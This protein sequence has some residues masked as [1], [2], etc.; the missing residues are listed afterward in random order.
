MMSPRNL[1]RAQYP[2]L[3][4]CQVTACHPSHSRAY[5]VLAVIVVVATT[6]NTEDSTGLQNQGF[7]A[8]DHQ[9][10]AVARERLSGTRESNTDHREPT[11]MISVKAL[12]AHLPILVMRVMRLVTSHHVSLSV[13]SRCP[14]LSQ[15]ETSLATHP[16]ANL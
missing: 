16:S 6:I 14:A 7:P 5:Q 12:G 8:K 10:I 2:R 11:E 15:P 3:L 1:L 13:R 4:N 9:V